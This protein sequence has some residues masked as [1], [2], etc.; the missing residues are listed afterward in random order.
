MIALP[1]VGDLDEALWLA[2]IDIAER[3]PSGWTL[4]GGQMVLLHAFEHGVWPPRISRD[5]DLAVDAR[6]DRRRFRRWRR[7]SPSS[8]PCWIPTQLP[9]GS[10]PVRSAAT[11][12]S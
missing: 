3:R 10:L 12:R 9:K 1:P 8:A 2:L 5:L 11:Q 7:R 6:C 4:V